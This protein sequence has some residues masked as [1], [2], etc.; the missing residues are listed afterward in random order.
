MEEKKFP[1]VY[2][3]LKDTKKIFMCCNEVFNIQSILF[4]PQYFSAVQTSTPS[5]IFYEARNQPSINPY[6]GVCDFETNL[7]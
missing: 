6:F 5:V 7:C 2:V 4:P 1:T 3:V